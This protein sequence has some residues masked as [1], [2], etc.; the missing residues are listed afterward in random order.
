MSLRLRVGILFGG[1]S[2]ESQA[3][4]VAPQ[5]AGKLRS[6]QTLLQLFQRPAATVMPF[7]VQIK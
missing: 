1:P 2:V 5:V 3:S 7:E 6:M 4:V